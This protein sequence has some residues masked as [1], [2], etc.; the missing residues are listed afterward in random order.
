ML[1]GYADF[2]SRGEHQRAH[3]RARALL[4]QPHADVLY[5]MVRTL[6]SPG[7]AMVLDEDIME[8]LHTRFMVPASWIGAPERS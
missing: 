2:L 5:A 8:I 3:G 1:R 6:D 7:A 4:R